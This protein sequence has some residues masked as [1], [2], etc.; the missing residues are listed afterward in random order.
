MLC[1]GSP[2]ATASRNCRRFTTRCR[3]CPLR[4]GTQPERTRPRFAAHTSHAT[5]VSARLKLL[6][7]SGSKMRSSR[8]SATPSALPRT[9][10]LPRSRAKRIACAR[11]ARAKRRGFVR[12]SSAIPSVSQRSPSASASLSSAKSSG[13][14][15]RSSRSRRPR[16]ARR[17]PR[18]SASARK[19]VIAR[20]RSSAKS[21]RRRPR[22]PRSS[23]RR[24]SRSGSCAMR[25]PH[26]R[27]PKPLHA[28]NS[29]KP[30]RRPR[31]L[32]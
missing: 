26:R 8:K 19:P 28:R 11:S 29:R 24:S 14:P 4:H 15:A 10:G 2:R 30:R 23:W 12:R 3:K 18:S 9:S 32:L 16:L 5:R 25:A 7:A 31:R 27:R 22:I 13:L 1:S 6:S 21:A 17:K 20:R